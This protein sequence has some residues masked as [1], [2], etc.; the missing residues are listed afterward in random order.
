[1]EA[2]AKNQTELDPVVDDGIAAGRLLAVVSSRPGQ[3][4]RCDGYI[5][6]GEELT[7]YLKKI[8]ARKGAKKEK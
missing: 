6:E 7:F 5:L 4:W 2:R 8:A 1:M 3:S